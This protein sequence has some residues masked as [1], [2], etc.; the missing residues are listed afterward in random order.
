[1]SPKHFQRF[2]HKKQVEFL[3]VYKNNATG[4]LYSCL[5]D[6]KLT[7][8]DALQFKVEGVVLT[9]MRDANNHM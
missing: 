1:M 9:F 4:E 2:R 6:I 5:D 3:A 8:P 7:Y